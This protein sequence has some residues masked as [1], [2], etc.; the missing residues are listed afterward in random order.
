M[1]G[2]CGDY[3]SNSENDF[4]SKYN[5]LEDLA[6][7]FAHSWKLYDCPL[8]PQDRPENIISPCEVNYSH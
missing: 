6:S 7:S 3:D 5:S 4:R 1:E 8:V 2:L